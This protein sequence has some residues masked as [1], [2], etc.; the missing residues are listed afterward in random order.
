MYG[1]RHRRHNRDLKGADEEF[2]FVRMRHGGP[3]FGGP[4]GGPFGGRG[5]GGP[6]G[7]GGPGW[8][9]RKRRGDVRLA[10]LM[11]L[12]EEPRNGYQLMQ[13]LQERSDGNW[14]P[15]PGSV[16][17][18]LA[19][20]EDEGLVRGTQAGESG[21]TFE[22]T[23]TGRE[24]LAERGEQRPPWEPSEDDGES[25][26]EFRRAIVSTAKAAWQVAQDGDEQ[27]IAKATELLNQTRRGLYRLLAGD[28]D[29]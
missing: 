17:P 11:L 6:G 23:D 15:S 24:H 27:Q 4:F 20:L 13:T 18:A 2:G 8:Q 7:P 9:R 22:L 29:S 21:R 1:E 19:Q 25:F 10:L 5:F 16:Y 12:A 14:R 26:G 3:G 28:A